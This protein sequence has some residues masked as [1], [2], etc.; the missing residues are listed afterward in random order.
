[1]AKEGMEKEV[2]IDVVSSNSTLFKESAR[3][4]GA[5]FDK[6]SRDFLVWGLEEARDRCDA[7]IER[8]CNKKRRL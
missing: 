2:M 6:Y 7:A 3:G 1:M 8:G 5:V 4:A